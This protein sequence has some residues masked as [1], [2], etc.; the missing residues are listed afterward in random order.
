MCAMQ[1]TVRCITESSRSAGRFH[2]IGETIHRNDFTCLAVPFLPD[3]V[4]CKVL[5]VLAKESL[6]GR[7]FGSEAIGW[8]DILE[9]VALLRVG[10][11][12]SMCL[13]LVVTCCEPEIK[14]AF[15]AIKLCAEGDPHW[16]YCWFAGGNQ[17]LALMAMICQEEVHFEQRNLCGCFPDSQISLMHKS[18]GLRQRC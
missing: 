9:D 12:P 13:F 16:Y 3:G 7:D 1:C 18:R 2:T 17:Q 10:G 11:A 6:Q 14:G 15:V 8:P 4:Q 5:L